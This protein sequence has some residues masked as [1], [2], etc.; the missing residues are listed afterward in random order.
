MRVSLAVGGMPAAQRQRHTFAALVLIPAV[1]VVLVGLWTV[2]G[3]RAHAAPVQAPGTGQALAVAAQQRAPEPGVIVLAPDGQRLTGVPP[4]PAAGTMLRDADGNWM[5]YLTSNPP[6]CW[7]WAA[8]W[9]RIPGPCGSQPLPGWFRNIV[10][11]TVTGCLVGLAGEQPE[12]GCLGGLLSTIDCLLSRDEAPNV[13]LRTFAHDRDLRHLTPPL[14]LVP[15]GF[16]D[17]V[18]RTP[19]GKES[20]PILLEI[21]MGTMERVRWQEKIGRYLPFL[22][23][24]LPQ[25]FG[26]DVATIAVAVPNTWQRV[27]ELK[28]WTEQALAQHNAAVHLG[29]FYFTRL[30]P[31][32]TGQQVFLSRRWLIAGSHKTSHLVPAAL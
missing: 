1:V 10:G 20:F 9:A 22:A 8:G 17:F 23:Q 11:K 28:T 5:T 6:A 4:T 7:H 30:E 16:L 29:L 2:P 27:R 13:K 21:D 31:G 26:T 12:I 14:S 32:L 25:R 15:D 18:I 19:T 24:E 3:S